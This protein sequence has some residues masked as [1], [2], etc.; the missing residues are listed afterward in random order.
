MAHPLR[1]IRPF[2]FPEIPSGPG[3]APMQTPVSITRAYAGPPG[4]QIHYRRATP[5]A[6]AVARR[7]LVLFHQNPAS[8]FEY[9]GLM[10]DI[11]RDRLVIAPDTPGYG[12]S[13]GPDAP[14]DMAGYAA[15]LL[16]A[17]PEMGIDAATGC[18]LYGFHTGALI[19]VEAALARPDLVRYLA[20]TGLPMRDATECAER[21]RAAHA[22]PPLDEAGE[23]M[24]GTARALWDYVVTARAQAVPLR[25]A[26]LN[27][28]D[29]LGALDRLHWA[30]FGVWSYDYT[31]RLP[32]LTCPCLLVQPDEDIRAPSL[33]AAA[34][35]PDHRI[36]ELPQWNRDIFDLPDAITAIAAQLR[37][38]FDDPSVSRSFPL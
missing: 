8:S 29:K 15:L 6:A 12:Q 10:R 3:S 14:P 21:L 23:G 22:T 2:F 28:R 30:Y 33:A 11:G 27:W 9:E 17:L 13:D 26:A 32:Q 25:R 38:F 20:L 35:I 16:A 1:V 4:R 18:D 7:P 19:A 36:A 24:L 31:A 37:G 34:L 5:V